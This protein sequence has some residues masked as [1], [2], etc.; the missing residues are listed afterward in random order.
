MAAGAEG[1]G[2]TERHKSPAC[3]TAV[4][5]GYLGM[6]GR[7]CFCTSHLTGWAQPDPHHPEHAPPLTCPVSQRRQQE[8]SGQRHDRRRVPCLPHEGQGEVRLRGD[9]TSTRHGTPC[10]RH[11]PLLLPLTALAACSA[12][13]AQP[14]VRAAASQARGWLPEHGV[15][16]SVALC[17]AHH[18]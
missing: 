12:P 5:S 9:A 6:L 4:T 10:T 18:A 17:T 8:P 7:G 3:A 16:V 2:G 11:C 13:D 15:T 14:S 1:A